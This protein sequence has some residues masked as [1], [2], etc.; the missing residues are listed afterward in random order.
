MEE[1]EDE[2]DNDVDAPWMIVGLGNPGPQYSNTKHNVGFDILD[3]IA[4]QHDLTFP[5]T[6]KK[7][8]QVVC[9]TIQNRT[10]YLVKPMTFMNNSGESVAPLRK[11]YNVPPSHV[12]IIYDD[13]DLPAGK[14][15]F[16]QKGGHGGHNGM[17]S[18]LARL[19][20][21]GDEAD[22]PAYLPRIK[23]GI[24][25][26]SSPLFPISAWVLSKTAPED[27]PAMERAT[28]EAILT[29][30]SIFALG[31]EKVGSGARLETGTADAG[32]GEGEGEGEGKD[33]KKRKV[34][35]SLAQAKRWQRPRRG[36]CA[37]GNPGDGGGVGDA[38]AQREAPVTAMRAALEAARE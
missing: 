4:R 2:T 32:P 21:T 23:V 6:L 12:I 13:L 27:V 15:R 38:A 7:N 30:E 18:L 20:P 10:V 34:R 19:P 36:E 33:S 1:V 8:A 16:R 14:V 11:L 29:A 31:L 37:S 17:R 35:V 26:P 24:G 25:R 22:A 3:A 28:A 9:G 5:S